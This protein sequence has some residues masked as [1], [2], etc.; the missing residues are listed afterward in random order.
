M[1]EVDSQMIRVLNG[2]FYGEYVFW[3]CDGWSSV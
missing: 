3:Y 1:E 2:N